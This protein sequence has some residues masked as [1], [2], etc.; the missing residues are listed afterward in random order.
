MRRFAAL[1]ARLDCANS[2]AQRSEALR[3]Y[4]ATAPPGDAAWAVA[5]LAGRGLG[6]LLRAE[7]LCESVCRAARVERWLFD[8]CLEASGDIAETIAHVLPPAR[9]AE[10]DSLASWIDGRLLGLPGCSVPTACER[11]LQWCDRLDP[12]GRELLVRLMLGR[13]RAMVDESLLLQSLAQH[14]GVDIRLLRLRWPEWTNPRVRPDPGRLA[15]LLRPQAAPAE[16]RARPYPFAVPQTVAASTGSSAG[17]AGGAAAWLMRPRQGSCR[18]QLVRRAEGVWLWSFSGELL[19]RRCAD[20]VAA[21]AQLPVD[22]V[23]DGELAGAGLVVFDLLEL[24]GVDLRDRPYV[25]RMARACDLPLLPPMAQAPEIGIADGATPASLLA[26]CRS[27]GSHGCLLLRRDAPYGAAQ[28]RMDLLPPPMRAIAAVRT[29]QSVLDRDGAT[30]LELGLA[31]WDRRP[32]DEVGLALALQSM[33]NTARVVD[34]PQLVPLAKLRLDPLAPGRT[35]GP[36]ADGLL[37]WI[38]EATMQR[39]GPVRLLRPGRLCEIE[40]D[41]LEPS[42]RRKSGLRLTGVRLQC[43]RSDCGLMDVDDVQRLRGLLASGERTDS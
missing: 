18:L 6:R 9:C 8:T 43:W 21:A 22:T 15:A 24:G 19:N 5:L 39:F 1:S 36:P 14:A 7:P 25:E 38:Q 30:W 2:N 3:D 29:A 28:A 37:E 17:L 16:D 13:G 11:A 23:L 10:S 35:A 20:I 33:A 40:F 41:D 34:G 12:A 42:A 26:R 4:L 27:G 31:V 32:A